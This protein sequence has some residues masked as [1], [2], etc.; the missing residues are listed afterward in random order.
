MLKQD[1]FQYGWDFMAK[2]LGTDMAAHLANS[3]YAANLSQNQQIQLR[4]EQIQEIN[5]T[6]D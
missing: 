2:L 5:K 6:I 1:D 4:N 3:E